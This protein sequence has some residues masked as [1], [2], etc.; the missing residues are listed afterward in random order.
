LFGET[1]GCKA[2]DVGIDNDFFLLVGNSM[3]AMRLVASARRKGI[4]LTIQL[5]F[6]RSRVSQLALAIIAVST[7]PGEEVP[8]F[9]L[10][11][12]EIP[13]RVLLDEVAAQ[14]NITVHDI[15]DV[16][17][18][19]EIDI[20]MMMMSE[21][22]PNWS[23]W[24]AAHIF[25]LPTNIQLGAYLKCWKELISARDIFRTR[26]MMTSMGPF[27]TVLKDNELYDF[28]RFRTLDDFLV[29]EK[30]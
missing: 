27:R 6:E 13:L 8:P 22:E 30:G 28:P 16:S 15:Q 1:F 10:I 21:P 9:S 19:R 4:G 26:F 11:Q 12:G 23:H 18:G 29:E 2:S 5:I 17:P 25:P 14:C 20:G 24:R 7:T 3:T